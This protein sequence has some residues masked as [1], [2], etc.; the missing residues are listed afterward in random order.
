MP[1]VVGPRIKPAS[2]VDVVKA[3]HVPLPHAIP[4]AS[5]YSSSP[6]ELHDTLTQDDKWDLRLVPDKTQG[7]TD[8]AHVRT[9]VQYSISRAMQEIHCTSLHSPTAAQPNTPAT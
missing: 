1:I 7:T 8:R 3:A 5:T 6:V 2:L 9:Y 4:T